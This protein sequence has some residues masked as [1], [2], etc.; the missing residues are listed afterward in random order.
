MNSER[1]KT[2]TSFINLNDSVLDVGCDHGYLAIYLKNN[3]LC[4]NIIVSD[5]SANALD[6][7]INNFKKYNVNINYYLS[8][9]LNDISE[10]YDTI[11]IAG[12]GTH[13]IINILKDKILPKK[14]LLASNNDHYLLRK[15]MQSIGYRLIE[16]KVVY[17]NKKY[18]PLMHFEKGIQKE[19]YST[20]MFGKSN[21]IEYYNYLIN[22]NNKIINKV[23]LK[24]KL[25]LKY[26]NWMLK[27]IIRSTEKK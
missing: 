3:N 25:K 7:A 12:M 9:G 18:Y 24:N 16:E 26:N 2:L 20:L 8:D 1:L 15:Y 17:E 5:I 22:K 13:T 11:V 19:K 27:K 14:I 4:K 10:Y 21:N 6:Y 23:P